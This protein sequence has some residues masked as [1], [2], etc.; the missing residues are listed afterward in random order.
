M[1]AEEL[2]RLVHNM[3]LDKPVLAQYF[4]YM[5]NFVQGNLGVSFHFKKSIAE[6]IGDRMWNTFYIA[7]LSLIISLLVGIPIGVLSATKQ[8]S[9]F[10]YTFSVLALA[11]ISIPGFFFG[12]S[13]LKIFSQEL[14]W[15]PISG[16]ETAG[17]NM[18]DFEY[19]FDVLWH[20]ILPSIVMGL[21][22]AAGFMR[23]TRSNML[24]VIR[25]DYI[26]TARAKGLKEKVVLYK[27]ALRNALSPVVTI[28][29]YHL[30]GLFSGAVI[31]EIIFS[32]PGMGQMAFQ[33]VLNRDYPLLM[34]INLFMA[35]LTLFGNLLADI[36]YG[37]VDPRIRHE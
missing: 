28:L 15:F 12:I 7:F 14:R 27:H 16:M 11:G 36:S 35:S 9:K 8:Y 10:D 2:A 4:D 24:E 22:G 29:G 33:A 21:I 31:T 20:S 37:F 25:Q 23:Y 19:F 1:T 34:G 26:R 3:G 18:N 30:P 13:L 5:S 32:W 6:L 17:A